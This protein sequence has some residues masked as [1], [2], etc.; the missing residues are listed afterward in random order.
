MCVL[1][2]AFDD[3]S[4]Q[5]G[6]LGGSGDQ[7][8]AEQAS[9]LS[10]GAAGYRGSSPDHTP[11]ELARVDILQ[12]ADDVPAHADIV[13]VG[14]E[15]GYGEVDREIGRQ[16]KSQQ[17]PMA[18][19]RRLHAEEQ[20]EDSESRASHPPAMLALPIELSL[21]VLEHAAGTDA[22]DA[23]VFS[24]VN[25]RW[26]RLALN[27]PSLWTVLDSRLGPS[28][29]RV[30][31]DR[32]QT[33]PLDVRVIQRG[34]ELDE[35]YDSRL[36]AFFAVALQHARRW[37]RL[38]VDTSLTRA[39]ELAT[40]HIAYFV[41]SQ[42]GQPLPVLDATVFAVN[43]DIA[44][45]PKFDKEP[46]RQMR[47]APFSTRSL[48]LHAVPA[49]EDGYFNRDLEHLEL[50]AFSRPGRGNL[51]VPDLALITGLLSKTPNLRELVFD[52]S[53][54][55]VPYDTPRRPE[56]HHLQSLSMRALPGNLLHQFV[57][58]VEIPAL[59]ILRLSLDATQHEL[60]VALAKLPRAT[61]LAELRIK[62][63]GP[64]VPQAPPRQLL[65]PTRRRKSIPTPGPITSWQDAIAFQDLEIFAVEGAELDNNALACLAT[66]PK[67][68]HLEL[69]SERLVEPSSLTTL[70]RQRLEDP[71]V[72]A[73]RY[74]E[75]AMCERLNGDM[76][77]K[78]TLQALVPVL[79]WLS[80]DPTDDDDDDYEPDE[81][82]DDYS[83]S[84]ADAT[85]D[86]DARE[87]T[88]KQHRVRRAL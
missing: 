29:A 70:V 42:D 47:A 56:L 81:D 30:F 8:V 12:A 82:D 6:R 63:P 74:L 17:R 28:C 45:D 59:R 15:I 85:L 75:V 22:Y 54:P 24:H 41:F 60:L 43:P 26:R 84:D 61:P 18:M 83:D 48:V 64:S 16:K 4:L 36:E 37:S 35:L 68:A 65:F 40:N 20:A 11:R 66:L 34:T 80:E 3:E 2:G 76:E 87:I 86:L 62:I 79:G 33:L 49:W 31:A 27:T 78:G 5:S 9:E 69:F 88:P 25:Q 55:S 32:S 7:Q 21:L 57:A 72:S 50:H 53:G 39:V 77:L 38:R 13:R 10:R 1:R 67:L 51:Q 19:R 71:H 52:A 44:H 73:L 23:R 14:G 58:M 46:Y